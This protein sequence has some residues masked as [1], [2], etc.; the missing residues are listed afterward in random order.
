VERTR[1]VTLTLALEQADEVRLKQLKDTIAAHR[2]DVPVTL[3]LT[4]PAEFEAILSV[5]NNLR[6][7]PTDTFLTKV[8]RLFGPKAVQLR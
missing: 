5:S 8:Q 3:T 7:C 1:G 4:S 2:G 6:V